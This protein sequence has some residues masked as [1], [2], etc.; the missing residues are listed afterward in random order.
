[1]GNGVALLEV[2]V[3]GGFEPRLYTR[4]PGKLPLE[5][6]IGRGRNLE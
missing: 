3:M 4:L 1:M 2:V 6:E 5:T